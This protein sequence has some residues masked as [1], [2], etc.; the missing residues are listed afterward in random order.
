MKTSLTRCEIREWIGAA[1]L[2]RPVMSR[3]VRAQLGAAAQVIDDVGLPAVFADWFQC[4]DAIKPLAD[5]HGK[6]YW[7]GTDEKRIA[8]AVAIGQSE[9]G[10]H[11]IDCD[12]GC[13]VYVDL[14]GETQLINTSVERFLLFIAHFIKASNEG[15][16]DC[17]ALR[18]A[19]EQIDRLALC[20]PEG[21]WSVTLESAEAG[22]F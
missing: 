16:E 2:R 13:V 10:K 11:V 5:A 21:I 6:S 4:A 22:L 12:T 15:F 3:A 9:F 1:N 19:F 20:N 7:V 17:E 14:S 8:H 18:T